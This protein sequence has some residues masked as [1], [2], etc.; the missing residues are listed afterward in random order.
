M[1]NLLKFGLKPNYWNEFI[2]KAYLNYQADA[3]FLTGIPYIKAT[4]PHAKGK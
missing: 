2:F 3:V 4:L 1:R